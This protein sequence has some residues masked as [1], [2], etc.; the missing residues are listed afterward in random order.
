MVSSCCLLAPVTTRVAFS[1][2]RAGNA[3]CTISVAVRAGE[4]LGSARLLTSPNFALP[5]GMVRAAK[6]SRMGT[7]TQAGRRIT[8]L[9]V[10]PQKPSSWAAP[11]RRRA[12]P[13]TLSAS[14]RGPSMAS[15]AGS[16]VNA[17]KAAIATAAIPP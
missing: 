2:V 12:R 15:T 6:M 11:T 16:T 13:G 8:L 4:S 3:V 1:A 7:A 17:T 5:K 9:A 14:M 10:R